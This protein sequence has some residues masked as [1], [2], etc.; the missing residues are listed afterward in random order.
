MII[1]QM[2]YEEIEDY[3]AYEFFIMKLH[4]VCEKDYKTIGIE[5]V[6]GNDLVKKQFCQLLPTKNIH[7]KQTVIIYSEN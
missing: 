1:R 6:K 7:P 4:C 2:L 3:N 5:K